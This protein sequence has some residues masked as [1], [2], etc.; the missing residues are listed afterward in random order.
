LAYIIIREFNDDTKSS[1]KSKI[2]QPYVEIYKKFLN[3]QNFQFVQN[4]FKF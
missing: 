1:L 4:C 3:H 2:R